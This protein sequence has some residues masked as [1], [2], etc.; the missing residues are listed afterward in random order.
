MFSSKDCREQR[1]FVR[2]LDLDLDLELQ[3]R[4]EE[5]VAV[6]DCFSMRL[7]LSPLSTSSSVLAAFA[8]IR[9]DRRRG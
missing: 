2:D 7:V 4:D 6:L 9:L 8:A 1:L 3:R 5:E